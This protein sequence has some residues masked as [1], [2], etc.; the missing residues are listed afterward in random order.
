MGFVN[1]EPKAKESH[2]QLNLPKIHAVIILSKVYQ[3]YIELEQNN[4]LYYF[5]NVYESTIV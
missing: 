2:S 5:I 4:I 3:W 1:M